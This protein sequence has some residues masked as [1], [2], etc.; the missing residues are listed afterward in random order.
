MDAVSSLSQVAGEVVYL[1]KTAD[2]PHTYTYDP[3]DGVAR[4]NIVNDPHTVPIFD[5]RPIADGL[6]LDGQGF[7]LIDAPTA[8]SDFYDEAQLRSVYYREAEDL[9]KQATGASRVVVFDHTIRRREQ[10]VEDRTPGTPRQPVTRIHGDYTEVSGPQRVRDLMG[11]EADD[12]LA[13]RF[14]IVNVWRP[15]RGP[16]FDAPLAVCDAGSVAGGDLVGQDL[17]YRDRI[18]EIYGLTYNPS[19][20]WYYA[21]AMRADEVLLLKCF[22]SATDGRARFMPHTSFADPNAPADMLPRE[23]IELRTLVFFD[24]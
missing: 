11:T 22:D 12:L 1:A 4:T 19:H 24:A 18:G 8:V 10:G 17:I 21:P 7:A 15:I 6:S 13:R 9:V 14:A 23:S 5:M 16:L 20:R 3:P 2:K